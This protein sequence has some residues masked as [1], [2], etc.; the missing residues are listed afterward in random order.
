MGNATQ[1]NAAIRT[2][3]W[4]IFEFVHGQFFTFIHASQLSNVISF[5]YCLRVC[6]CATWDSNSSKHITWT[7]CH[8]FLSPSFWLTF[9]SIGLSW[10]KCDRLC[11]RKRAHAQWV[12]IESINLPS[13]RNEEKK[14]M[15][16]FAWTHDTH[17]I[18]FWFNFYLF[19]NA[20]KT[21]FS[22]KDGIIKKKL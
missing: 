3:K 15:T 4:T 17:M 21:I 14:K 9:I 5:N 20:M 2:N 12:P 11:V 19:A 10:D 18:D 6:V 13:D 1:R 8:L 7:H 16:Q 22:P